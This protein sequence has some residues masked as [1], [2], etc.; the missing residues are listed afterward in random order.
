MLPVS[1][2]LLLA[3]VVFTVLIKEIQVK[4]LSQ[5]KCVYKDTQVTFLYH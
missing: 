1:A 3:S 2:A 4:L 5:L